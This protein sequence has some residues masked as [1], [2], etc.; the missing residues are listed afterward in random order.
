MQHTSVNL[1]PV[2]PEWRRA[3][4][5]ATDG[6]ASRALASKQ[7]Q[8]DVMILTIH[9]TEDDKDLTLTTLRSCLKDEFGQLVWGSA[10]WGAAFSARIRRYITARG[11]VDK[12][13]AVPVG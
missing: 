8:L 5:P 2:F 6:N 3:N 11:E 12:L 9:V 4:E 7:F 10:A 1:H 13:G